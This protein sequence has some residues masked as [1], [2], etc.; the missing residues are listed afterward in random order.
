LHQA[1]HFAHNLCGEVSFAASLTD[2]RRNVLKN[3]MPSFAVPINGDELFDTFERRIA[4]LAEIY[5]HDDDLQERRTLPEALKGRDSIAR[6]IAPGQ[7][8]L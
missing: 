2:L 8:R 1:I 4:V 6:R 3:K 7:H 5:F